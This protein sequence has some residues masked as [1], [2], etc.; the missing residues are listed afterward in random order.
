MNGSAESPEYPRNL[1]LIVRPE[2][3]GSHVAQR[4]DLQE[5]GAQGFV[6]WCLEDGDHVVGSY[7]PV[8]LLQRQPMLLGDLTAVVG[9]LGGVLDI[10]YALVGP[11]HED[12]VTGHVS[13]SS[14]PPE[15]H[16]VLTLP[17]STIMP[18]D[19]I[20]RICQDSIHPTS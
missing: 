1:L 19:E 3:G 14:L 18:V 16:T 4:S 10:P 5:V 12:N 20:P 8:S 17:A 9:A 11:I 15:K 2:H 7:R 13:S 6:V